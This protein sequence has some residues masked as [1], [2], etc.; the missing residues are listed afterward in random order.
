M[1]RVEGL[2]ETSADNQHHHKKRSPQYEEPNVPATRL[3]LK[4]ASYDSVKT[5]ENQ[6]SKQFKGELS[7]LLGAIED[8]PVFRGARMQK[9]RRQVD[10]QD[11]R[12]RY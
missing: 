3:D 1:V 7:F 8:W 5:E 10:G 4:D 9:A 2:H 12:E 6:S 11:S